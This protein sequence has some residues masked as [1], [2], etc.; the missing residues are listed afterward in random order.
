MSNDWND[1]PFSVFTAA[2]GSAVGIG[3]GLMVALFVGT[4]IGFFGNGLTFTDTHDGFFLLYLF[5]IFPV[6][7]IANLA[8]LSGLLTALA[9]ITLLVLYLKW[10]N[11]KLEFLVLYTL[12]VGLYVF[13]GVGFAQKDPAYYMSWLKFSIGCASVIGTYIAIRGAEYVWWKI[14]ARK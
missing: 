8:R 6:N 5:L 7:L 10:D 1:Y 3:V 12:S 13:L 9:S 2:L 14:Q 11:Y 4:A